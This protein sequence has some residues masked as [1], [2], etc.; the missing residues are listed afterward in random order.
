MLVLGLYEEDN[1]QNL[2][3]MSFDLF[4]KISPN[5][6]FKIL[7]EYTAL[8]NMPPKEKQF[9]EPNLIKVK[10]ETTPVMSTYLLAVI[11]SDFQYQERILDGD[12]NVSSTAICLELPKVSFMEVGTA[13]LMLKWLIVESLRSI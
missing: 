4:D 5:I 2:N 13:D 9:I 11:V 1:L 6:S 12:Y 3:C 10:F 8:S 7:S